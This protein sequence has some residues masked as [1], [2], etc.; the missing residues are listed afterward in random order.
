[1]SLPQYEHLILL[2]AGLVTVTCP[3]LPV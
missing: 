3:Y 1:M 2:A